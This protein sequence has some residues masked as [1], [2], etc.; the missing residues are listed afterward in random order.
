MLFPSC[1]VLN[2]L[3]E[4][5]NHGVLSRRTANG[6]RIRPCSPAGKSPQIQAGEGL[7]AVR[8]LFRPE[9]VGRTPESWGAVTKDREWPKDSPMFSGGEVPADSGRR[10]IGCCSHP[11]PS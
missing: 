11:V 6:L 3:G 5:R 4:L 2:P 8:I 10:R 1:S 9:S 7:D